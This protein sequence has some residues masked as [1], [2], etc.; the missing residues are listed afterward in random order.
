MRQTAVTAAAEAGAALPPTHG[1]ERFTELGVFAEDDYIPMSLVTALWQATGALR[2]EG[3]RDLC[4]ALGGPSPL[5]LDSA[6]G[7]R[8]RLHDVIRELLRSCLGDGGVQRVNGALVNAVAA[9]LSLADPATFTRPWFG[10]G[11]ALFAELLLDLTGRS[12]AALHP[13]LSTTE[14]PSR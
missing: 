8:V 12:T 4:S 7:G 3:S 9:S 6:R 5:E 14:P 2:P 11:D 10:W 13:R 1:F